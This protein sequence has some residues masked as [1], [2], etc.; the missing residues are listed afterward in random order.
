M[1]I[2]S[3]SGPAPRDF[4]RHSFIPTDD[5]RPPVPDPQEDR[6]RAE[7]PSPHADSRHAAP[8]RPWRRFWAPV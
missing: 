7:P 1:G 6:R 5:A 2:P 4:G 3:A 8:R